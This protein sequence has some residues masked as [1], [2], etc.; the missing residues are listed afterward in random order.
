MI[1][2]AHLHLGKD[3]IY[4]GR[5]TTEQS[6]IDA[7]E[8]HGVNKA[9]IY[10]ANSNT[11]LKDERVRHM[12]VKKLCDKYPGKFVGICSV[13]PNIGA[14]EYMEEV[15]SYINQG[16]E[17]I[18]VNPL[19]HAWDPTTSKAELVFSAAQKYNVPLSINTGIGLPFGI[20]IKLFYLCKKYSNVKVII[21]HAGRFIYNSQYIVLGRECPNVYF[22]TSQG[23]N[24]R[25]LKS[26]VKMLGAHRVMM[27]SETLDE[28][29]HSLY[30]YRHA[31]LTE[32]ELR[33]CL[34]DTVKSLFKG[35]K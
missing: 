2:D 31:G 3:L 33:W 9:V 6:I 17:G 25:V 26:Y 4:E 28:I 12:E 1:I 14:K 15:E 7:L 35:L 8:E 18:N 23:P 22:E 30:A 13:N 34:C 11:G 5:D 32:E 16:Y 29:A 21:V 19:V 20:P 10:P 24:M 27:G